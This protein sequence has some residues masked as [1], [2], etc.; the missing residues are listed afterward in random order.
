[1]DEPTP[2]MTSDSFGPGRQESGEPATKRQRLE[3]STELHPNPNRLNHLRVSTFSVD[4]YRSAATLIW[5]L[6]ANRD[7][8]A[9][10]KPVDNVRLDIPPHNTIIKHP[11]DLGTVEEKLLLSNRI[12]NLGTTQYSQISETAPGERYWS[13]DEFMADVRLV[14]DNA[15]KFHG[16]VHAGARIVRR[17]LVIFDTHMEKRRAAEELKSVIPATQLAEEAENED[18][19]SDDTEDESQVADASTDTPAVKLVETLESPQDAP[20]LQEDALVYRASRQ[21][22]PVLTE[23]GVG[24][25]KE[26]EAKKFEQEEDKGDDHINAALADHAQNAKVVIDF[27]QR[28]QRKQAQTQ[29]TETPFATTTKEESTGKD[30]RPGHPKPDPAAAATPIAGPSELR[31]SKSSAMESYDHDPVDFYKKRELSEEIRRLK[32]KTLTD[33]LT[34]I[35]TALRRDSLTNANSGIEADIDRLAPSVIRKLY[36]KVVEPAKKKREMEESRTKYVWDSAIGGFRYDRTAGK[37]SSGRRDYQNGVR[38]DN[39][40]DEAL[41]TEKI[42]MLEAR[43]SMFNGGGSGHSST[44]AQPTQQPTMDVDKSVGTSYERRRNEDSDSGSVRPSRTGKKDYR[45]GQCNRAF[46]TS[47]HLSRHMRIHT[48]ER[49]QVCPFPACHHT[50]SRHDNLLQHY[51]IQ[52]LPKSAQPYTTTEVKQALEDMFT[53]QGIDR[54]SAPP[55]P[56]RPSP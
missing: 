13:V 33:V 15:L 23:K 1:M 31:K 6:K 27:L 45:C 19:E 52:H 34:I 22:L 35:Q 55:P 17:M 47:G 39:S 2:L 29:S 30:P 10:L 37:D 43:L 44:A 4:Q 28:I 50:C 53:Q 14:F 7:A 54:T 8:S 24:E 26:E 56:S 48:G 36:R 18:E 46:D 38:W 32:G 42:S 11:L 21:E 25:D 41:Q 49:R 16:E 51:R 5:Q 3:S 9:F 40:T 12:N 20:K